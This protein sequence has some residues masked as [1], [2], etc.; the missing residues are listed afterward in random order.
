MIKS[1]TQIPNIKRGP[2][3][4]GLPNRSPC[5]R[6]NVEKMQLWSGNEGVYLNQT[7]AFAQQ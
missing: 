2:R 5:Q 4:Q 6:D 1:L 7:R 3:V